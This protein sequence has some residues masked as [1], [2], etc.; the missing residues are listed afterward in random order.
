MKESTSHSQRI[1]AAGLENN[2]GEYQKL[3]VAHD[4]E[5]EGTRRLYEKLCRKGGPE[6]ARQE[7]RRLGYNPSLI[8]K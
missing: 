5:V 2:M 1:T 8:G 7:L 4:M 6:F 3:K